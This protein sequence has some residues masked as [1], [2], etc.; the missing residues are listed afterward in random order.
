MPKRSSKD[1]NELA[2]S[3][4]DQIIAETESEGFGK[5]K[6][7]KNPAAVALGKLGGLKGGKARAEKLTA[8]RR[9]EIAT[10]AAQVASGKSHGTGHSYLFGK[11]VSGNGADETLSNVH[12]WLQRLRSHC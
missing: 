5:E 7:Q 1:E 9:S 12:R 8:L 10:K 4:V 2:K 3:I 11:V 6:P